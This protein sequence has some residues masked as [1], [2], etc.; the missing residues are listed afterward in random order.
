M[1]PSGDWNKAT[2]DSAVVLPISAW[3]FCYYGHQVGCPRLVLTAAMPASG[4]AGR[5]PASECGWGSAES[6]QLCHCVSLGVYAWVYM[7][8]S[9]KLEPEFAASSLGQVN[10]P[11]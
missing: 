1:S 2:G 9:I 10:G 7:T 3:L 8:E 11:C 5:M 4:G 6:K